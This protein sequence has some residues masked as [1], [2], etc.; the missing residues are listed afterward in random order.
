MRC[1]IIAIA[2]WPL[3]CNFDQ[4]T[5]EIKS[6]NPEYVDCLT[7]HWSSGKEYRPGVLPDLASELEGQ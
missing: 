1:E 5:I 3:V 2:T 4:E 7:D 6:R